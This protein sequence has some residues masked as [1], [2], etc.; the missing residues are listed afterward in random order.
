MLYTIEPKTVDMFN[1]GLF[2][3]TKKKFIYFLLGLGLC[4]IAI[5]ILFIIVKM[6]IKKRR[7]SVEPQTQSITTLNNPIY[8]D[9]NEGSTANLLSIS[10]SGSNTT[11]TTI[12][13]ETQI[14]EAIPMAKMPPNDPQ[15]SLTNISVISETSI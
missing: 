15:T 4:F 9:P 14:K 11:I 8:R 1:F 2:T 6:Y 5:I 7:T 13:S 10:D 3:L 12:T